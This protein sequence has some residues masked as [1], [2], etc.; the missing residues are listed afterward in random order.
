MQVK[1]GLSKR[2]DTVLLPISLP[3]L[4]WD[5]CA[6]LLPRSALSPLPSSS[7]L[8]SSAS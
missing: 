5:S 4:D 7:C 6:V 8:V 2:Q 3:L 1:A